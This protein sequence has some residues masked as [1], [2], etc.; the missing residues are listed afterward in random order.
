MKEH[1]R[2][3][4]IFRIF[5]DFVD[6][7]QLPMSK[8]VS[9]TIDGAPAMLGCSNGFIAKEE[10]ALPDFLNKSVHNTPTS[11][12]CKNAEHERC[13]NGCVNESRRFYSSKMSSEMTV[14]CGN[15]EECLEEAVESGKLRIEDTQYEMCVRLKIN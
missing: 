10:A 14:L 6:K 8:L 1:I 4:D 9:I 5:K 3:D 7:T 15:T 2:S 11:A 12:M 13:V